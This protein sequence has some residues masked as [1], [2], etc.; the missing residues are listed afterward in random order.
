M[1]LSFLKNEPAKR[2]TLGVLAL[3]L[4][5][6]VVTGR[7]KPSAAAP[8]PVERIETRVEV[9]ADIDLSKLERSAAQAPRIDPFARASF[10]RPAP[11]V[12]ASAEPPQP[13]APPLPFRYMGRLTENGKT[14]VFVLR[15]EDIVSIAPGQK[16]D[17]D[18]RVERITETAISMTYLPLKTRQSLE[19]AQ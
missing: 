16:I 11:Q 2:A 18:Y 17:A 8:Q 13:V 9:V 7:E 12:L 14:E 3:V 19:L 5:A 15:G 1:S 4:V 6:S 10:A